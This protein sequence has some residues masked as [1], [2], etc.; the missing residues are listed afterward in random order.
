MP[1]LAIAVN[2]ATENSLHD[3]LWE[4]KWFENYVMRN[5]LCGYC[6]D[7]Q[8]LPT[9]RIM[10]P[11]IVDCK[12]NIEKNKTPLRNLKLSYDVLK[13]WVWNYKFFCK[14][15]DLVPQYKKKI[16][17]KAELEVMIQKISA[18]Q[19]FNADCDALTAVKDA[20][21]NRK[22]L[23]HAWKPYVKMIPWQGH[24]WHL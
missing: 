18:H 12:E 9:L 16:I 22:L 11:A 13:L 10:M 5:K 20:L 19:Q 7:P 24:L 23:N 2:F 8:V 15:K 4:L 1:N 21:V 3:Q 17:S 14:S 6:S